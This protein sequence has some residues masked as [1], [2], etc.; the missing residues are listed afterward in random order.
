[1]WVRDGP[2]SPEGRK[3]EKEKGEA[4]IGEARGKEEKEEGREEERPEKARGAE[5]TEEPPASLV[6]SLAGGFLGAARAPEE[7]WMLCHHARQ[8]SQAAW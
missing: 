4:G 3:P 8:V 1:L 2:L 7:V 5:V 6:R